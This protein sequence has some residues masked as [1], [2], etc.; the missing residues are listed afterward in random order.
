MPLSL[1]ASLL[2]ATSSSCHPVHTLCPLL[3]SRSASGVS[4]LGRPRSS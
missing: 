4:G 1:A 3:S 2:L